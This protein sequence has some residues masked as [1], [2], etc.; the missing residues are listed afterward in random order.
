MKSCLKQI[1]QSKTIERFVAKKTGFYGS[2]EIEEA[3]IDMICEHIRDIKTKYSDAKS[4]KSGDELVAAK[5][6]F[7]TVDL[8]EWM[9]KLEF[10]VGKDGFSVGSKLSLA[11]VSI[12]LLL[13]EFFDDK[14]AAVASIASCPGLT[15]ISAG[16]AIAGKVWFDS[17]PVTAI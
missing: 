17:R 7:V 15:S 3:L 9:S 4:N 6:A 1:G 5:N 16:V 13:N 14:S 8:P 10:C 2:N 11:D 12:Y